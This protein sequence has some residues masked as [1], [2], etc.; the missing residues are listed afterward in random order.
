MSKKN[1]IRFLTSLSLAG[2]ISPLAFANK[3]D[4]ADKVNTA[5][6]K[7]QDIS[8]TLTQNPF[9]ELKQGYLLKDF[10]EYQNTYISFVDKIFYNKERELNKHI[11]ELNSGE[12]KFKDLC[13]KILE[14]KNYQKYFS[15][16]NKNIDYYKSDLQKYNNELDNV[17]DLGKKSILFLESY[18]C[19]LKHDS[20]PGVPV[21]L[22]EKMVDNISK[23]VRRIISD[24]KGLF[25]NK[26]YCNS[27]LKYAEHYSQLSDYSNDEAIRSITKYPNF[28]DSKNQD[29]SE[30]DNWYDNLFTNKK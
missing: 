3:I 16:W 10:N 30:I 13:S 1:M 2:S 12:Q 5:I 8:L 24:L 9:P 17:I 27:W 20:T 21:N 28:D 29:T 4:T 7:T 15:E 6:G 26:H 11:G 14:E 25:V 18:K 19:Y 23:M 22:K